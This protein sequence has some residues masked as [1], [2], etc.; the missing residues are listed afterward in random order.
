MVENAIMTSGAQDESASQQTLDPI[1]QSNASLATS[2][3]G[4]TKE[5]VEDFPDPDED[6][7]D[8]LDGKVSSCPVCCSLI[9]HIDMLD[10]FSAVKTTQKADTK[11][12]S[13]TQPVKETSTKDVNDLSED[14]FA[15]QLQAGMTDFM[16][17]FETSPDM[18]S[19]FESLLAELGGNPAEQVAASVGQ[20]AHEPL[21][22][23]TAG[24]SSGSDRL[25]AT[26]GKSSGP[27]ED[28]KFQETIKKTMERMQA[29]GEQATAAA[30]EETEEDFLAEM[31]KAM[32]A[33]GATGD[34]NE[35]DFSKMILGMMEQLTNK[36]ILYEPMK[37]LD[38]KFP[39]WMKNNAAQA[40][41]DDLKRYRE[42]QSFVRQ[43]VERFELSTY[44]DE[45][46]A[47]REFIVDR[48]Q[49]VRSRNPAAWM[50][51]LAANVLTPL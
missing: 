30:T 18:Q 20:H 22:K 47:D 40:K 12:S 21:G 3:P 37:E 24:S 44:K 41:E 15:K 34:G 36:E 7:L 32:Q 13:S 6:D 19:Q 8:D 11:S 35:E 50:I 39:Q 1:E 42:Q 25:N 5:A 48:M 2:I 10:D 29:S 9:E 17:E 14:E 31:M 51:Q 45:N 23:V 26:A 38:D 49:K 43:I 16:K 4:P 28:A 27:S 33:G 46:P